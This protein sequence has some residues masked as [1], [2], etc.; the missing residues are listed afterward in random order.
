MILSIS[1]D[2]GVSA[3]IAVPIVTINLFPLAVTVEFALPEISNAV[4]DVRS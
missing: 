2:S 1:N 3:A 4:T